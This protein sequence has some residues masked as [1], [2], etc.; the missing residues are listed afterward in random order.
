M[1]SL[2]YRF[3]EKY[4]FP[5]LEPV[6]NFFA[7]YGIHRVTV[8]GIPALI[9]VLIAIKG[10]LKSKSKTL[11]VIYI[12]GVIIMIIGIIKFQFFND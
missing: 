1:K 3:I 5:L 4:I 11:L 9:V 8:S 10:E 7:Q 12:F 6:E 2:K